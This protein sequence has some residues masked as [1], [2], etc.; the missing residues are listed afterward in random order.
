MMTIRK[1]VL[2]LAAAALAVVGGTATATAATI[3][4]YGGTPRSP[5]S[6]DPD[7][8]RAELTCTGVCEAMFAFLHP[9]A[10]DPA[11]P[12]ADDAEGFDS[13]YGDFFTDYD[14]TARDPSAELAFLED[15]LQSIG[16]IDTGSLFVSGRQEQ[17][18]VE[19]GEAIEFTSSAE[20]L[21]LKVGN[22]PD[23]AVIR[24][25]SANNLFT[26]TN[27]PG[28]GGGLSHVTEVGVVP[29][30]AAGFL[31]VGALGGLAAAGRRRRKAA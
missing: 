9:V 7:L 6:Y 25:G 15:A 28:A 3:T 19:D 12:G 10:G 17:P 26:Y 18:D 24:N 22:S 23:L 4:L 1:R 14:T 8:V 20:Y 30:P 21:V 13:A 2:A 5:D 16:G 29:L 11:M 27:F 31:L